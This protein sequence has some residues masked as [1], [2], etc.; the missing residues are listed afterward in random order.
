MYSIANPFTCTIYA[1]ILHTV[2]TM[3]KHVYNI[4]AKYKER[5]ERT[6]SH[7]C[8]NTHTH[9]NTCTHTLS[10]SCT[11]THSFSLA[12]THTLSLS[13]THTLFLAHTLSCTHTHTHT[14]SL[15]CTRTLS[16]VWQ[17][18]QS[19]WLTPEASSSSCSQPWCPRGREDGTRQTWTSLTLSVHR[20]LRQCWRTTRNKHTQVRLEVFE[21]SPTLTM[22]VVHFSTLPM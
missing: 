20:E 14:H 12:H 16:Q 4:L 9:T 2:K 21:V 7:A 11:N 6:Q 5:R 17:C 3:K 13:C 15:S 10:L 19:P 1:H 8:R 18:S 22:Y